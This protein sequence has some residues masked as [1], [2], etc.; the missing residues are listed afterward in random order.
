VLFEDRV[1]RL[2]DWEQ[3]WID[4]VTLRMSYTFGLFET[5]PHKVF[6]LVGAAG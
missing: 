1:A 2:I 6:S 5:N 4:G 3:V